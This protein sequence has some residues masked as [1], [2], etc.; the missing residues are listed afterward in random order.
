MKRSLL[1]ALL[2]ACAFAAFGGIAYAGGDGD[3]GPECFDDTETG[4]GDNR[5]CNNQD[6]S[7]G[8][9]ANFVVSEFRIGNTDEGAPEGFDQLEDRFVVLEDDGSPSEDGSGSAIAFLVEHNCEAGN[10]FFGVFV[11]D[12]AAGAENPDTIGDGA[13]VDDCEGGDEV[14]VAVVEANAGFD[15]YNGEEN[16]TVEGTDGAFDDDID[17]LDSQSN[18]VD[19]GQDVEDEGD[20]MGLSPFDPD[21]FVAP[22]P[23]NGE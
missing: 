21:E 22:E 3:A 11:G 7:E 16:V 19:I 1:L 20:S 17:N 10:T 14:T 8:A 13:V 12:Q 15:P 2:T 9:D 6:G 5:D 4:P 23:P 18:L